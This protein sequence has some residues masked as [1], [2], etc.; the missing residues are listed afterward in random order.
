MRTWCL[1]IFRAHI[2]HAR[3]PLSLSLYLNCCCCNPLQRREAARENPVGHR[4]CQKFGKSI[5]SIQGFVLFR[6]DVGRYHH[7]HIVSTT[8]HRNPSADEFNSFFFTFLL[9]F[10]SVC[11]SRLD[12]PV[13]HVRVPI[14]IPRRTDSGVHLLGDWCDIVLFAVPTGWSTSGQTLF[15]GTSRKMGRSSRKASQRFVE[16]HAVSAYD[17][18]LAELVHQSGGTGHWCVTVSICCGHILRCRTA[19]VSGHSSGQN[20]EYHDKLFGRILVTID[21]VAGRFRA[22]VI[23]AGHLQETIQKEIAIETLRT[24]F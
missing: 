6:G 18:V 22:V 11:H 19:I 23:D 12:V 7:L 2:I 9:Q 8:G 21:V 10:T 13:H 20:I 14:Q 15:S 17:A 4:R 24:H 3:I 16:L 1:S 5:K